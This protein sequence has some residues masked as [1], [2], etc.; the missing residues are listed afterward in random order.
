MEKLNP[1]LTIT[2]S[3]STGGSGVQA[4][5]QTITELGGFA[6][7]AITSVTLQNTLGIQE[8]YDLSAEVVRGQIEAVVNDLRPQV[9][10]IGLL[11]TAETVRAVVSVLQKYH[12]RHVIYAPVAVSS[13]GEELVTEEVKTIIKGEMLPYCTL[14]LQ[15]DDHSMH[16]LANRYASAVAVFLHQGDSPEEAKD[17]A[18][19]YIRAKMIRASDLQGRGS[20][21]YQEFMGMVDQYYRTNSD[22]AFYADQ[23]N[24]SARYLAQ[25]TRRI[26]GQPPKAII[27]ERLIKEIE[28]ALKMTTKTMQEIAYE[29]GFSSQAYLTKFFR[30]MRGIPPSQFRKA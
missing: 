21:L 1:I 29:Y 26:S 15:L 20:E 27:D 3:D 25:V 12:P 14:V 18:Q 7:S 13:R 8:F 2:G 28:R 6:V 10:K 24:V 9:V 19:A 16:G 11:R 4:D 23:M 5:I 17:K 30:K 22:V